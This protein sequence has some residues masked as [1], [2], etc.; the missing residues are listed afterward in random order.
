ML[1]TDLAVV[2][3]IPTGK[4]DAGGFRSQR[5]P[6]LNRIAEE[7]TPSHGITLRQLN[8]ITSKDPLR[9]RKGNRQTLNHLNP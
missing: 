2:E 6:V 4:R 7:V 5:R 1:E 3:E 9:S 8:Q